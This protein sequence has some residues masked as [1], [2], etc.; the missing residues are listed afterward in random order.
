MKKIILTLLST[1][2]L[3]GTTACRHSAD[4][5]AEGKADVAA[6]MD[7]AAR[8]APVYAQGFKV[9]YLDNGVRLVEIAD[10]QK[11]VKR[12]HKKDGTPTEN[13]KGTIKSNYMADNYRLALV[14]RGVKAEVPAGYTRVEVP[15]RRTI[16]MT[17]IQLSNF[18]ALH[19]LDV[20]KGITGTKNLFN[21][22]I[23]EGVKRG[24]IVKIGME[25]N[26]D[27]ELIMA[28]QPDVIFISPFK[29][30]GYDVLK[31]TGITLIPHLGSKE[32]HPL[33]QAEW[34]KLVGM[35]VGKEK[36]ANSRFK[37]IEERYNNLKEQVKAT[38]NRPTI[39]SGEM[40]GGNWSAIGSQNFLAQIFRD[41]G[42]NYVISDHNTGTIQMEFEA[43]YAAAAHADYWRILNSY[44][45]KFSYEAL[46][47]AEPRYAL[48]DAFKK[49]G[50]IYCN[51]KYTP[52]YE[53]SPVEPDVLLADLVFI[54]HPEVMPRDYRPKYY[55]L[56]K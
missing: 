14:P 5:G 52:Y 2:L 34:L 32:L 26:C 35:F 15:I 29:R 33:G 9:K 1:A 4:K 19:S 11:H 25:G 47:S 38:T 23:L 30:G 31:E 28:A 51:M 54:F 36:E 45:G 8:I 55:H 50:V 12:H 10:P 3:L 44:P 20:V 56:M 24:G 13:K 43:L 27:P 49:K 48:F 41:A 21:K 6:I 7:S 39:F 37:A 18:T 53:S 16:V 46:K 42:A 22:E 17:A 40:H